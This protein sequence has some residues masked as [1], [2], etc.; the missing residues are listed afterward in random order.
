[1]KEDKM[2]SFREVDYLHLTYLLFA[3]SSRWRI[4][5]ADN[6]FVNV[7][8]TFLLFIVNQQR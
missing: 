2:C 8:Q 3:R 7:F 5:V 6:R 4:Y 1:M